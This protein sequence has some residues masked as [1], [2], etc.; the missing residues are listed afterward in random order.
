MARPGEHSLLTR[1]WHN[2]SASTGALEPLGVE[3]YELFSHFGWQ[4][5][6][7]EPSGEL[8]CA[9]HLSE[10]RRAVRTLGE[11]SFESATINT[12]QGALEVI[13]DQLYCL[14]TDEFPL[15]QEHP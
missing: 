10:V 6:G 5:F 12:R 1:H 13:G 8:N 7:S 9:P 15:T 4:L 2:Q 14:L 3:P 11:V